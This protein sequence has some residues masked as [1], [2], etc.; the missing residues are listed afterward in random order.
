[1][2]LI[3]EVFLRYVVV[4]TFDIKIQKKKTHWCALMFNQVWF[5]MVLFCTKMAQ[6]NTSQKSLAYKK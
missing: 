4:D 1:M 2:W 3:N 5:E 6:S